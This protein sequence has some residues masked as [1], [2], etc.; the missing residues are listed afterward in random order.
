MLPKLGR[1]AW[2][3]ALCVAGVQSKLPL[4]DAQDR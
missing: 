1:F 4:V 2:I 3:A